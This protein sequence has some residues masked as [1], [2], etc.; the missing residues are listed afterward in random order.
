M[1]R[2]IPIIMIATLATACNVERKAT[3]ADEENVSIKGD[4]NGKVKFDVP[5]VKGELSL[6][7]GVMRNGDVDIDG[8]K[9]MPGSKVTGF[10]VMAGEGKEDS[11]DIGYSAPKP[12]AD[13]T[14]YFLGEFKRTGASAETHGNA[15]VATTKDGDK[16]NITVE[17][18][19]AGTKGMVSLR[20]ND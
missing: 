13:V 14:A 6:P 19:G 1:R 18:D 12:P 11:V 4:A 15:V 2:A 17:P 16:V 9:L 20:S 5:F 8:V 3:G 10:S 7:S